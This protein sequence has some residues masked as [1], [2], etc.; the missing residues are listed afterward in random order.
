[1][2]PSSQADRCIPIALH[3]KKPDERVLPFWLDVAL[4][5][6]A[7]LVKPLPAWVKQN[8]D[9]LLA[10]A[11]VSLVTASPGFSLRQHQFLTPLLA[12]AQVACGQWLRK[13]RRAMRRIFNT[14]PVDPPSNGLQLLSDIRDYFTQEH[15]PARIYTTP[16]LE[17]LNLLEDRPWQKEKKSGIL[18]RRRRS[19]R[20]DSRP[21]PSET[22]CGSF[23]SMRRRA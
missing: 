11:C 1:D 22:S 3:R 5:Q 23:S 16:L 13:S 19:S 21:L 6:A 4:M 15:D 7:P 12:I 17:Y 10:A 8:R 20:K 2:L 18:G 14:A 9:P